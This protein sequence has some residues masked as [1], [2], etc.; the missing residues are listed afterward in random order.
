MS[1]TMLVTG[2]AGFIGS[3]LAERLHAS[4]F[5]V[6]VLDNLSQGRREWVGPSS[7]FLEGDLTDLPTCRRACEGVAGVFHCAAMSKVA[8]SLD[9]FEFCTEQNIIGTQNLLIAAR[10][11]RVRKLVY[12]GS[13]TYYGNGAPPQSETAL[14]NCLNPYAV[15]KY[16]GE[17]FCEVFTRLYGLPTVSLRYFNVYGPRQP[18][19]GAYA[20]VLGIFLD[21]HRRG[22]PLTVHGDGSQRRDFIHVTDV[23]EANLAAY[24]SEVEGTVMNVGSGTN[25]SIQEIADMISSRQVRLAR[26]PGDAEAT[27]ADIS[28]IRRLLE[29]EPKVAFPQGLKQLM[30]S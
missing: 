30:E 25:L 22:E 24:A 7:E 19:V 13:S 11:A 27:L 14:P 1:E 8:P 23:V 3:H 4:G 6:R 21:Q 29:W 26:R 10:D 5:K 20:L 2:G 9:K 12:S 28:R 15:S 16:V 17:Q 18:A